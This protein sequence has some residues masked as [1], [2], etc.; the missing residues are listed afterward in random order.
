MSC[1]RG[2]SV[3]RHPGYRPRP[4]FRTCRPVAISDLIFGELAAALP[5]GSGSAGSELALAGRG[6]GLWEV[7]RERSR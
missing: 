5:G 6:Q 2:P 3:A 1:E 4:V 7:G